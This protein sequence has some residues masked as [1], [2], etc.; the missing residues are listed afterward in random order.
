MPSGYVRLAGDY[1][2]LFP[3]RRERLERLMA[4]AGPAPARVLEL[5]C[6]PGAYLAALGRCGYQVAGLELD[7]AMHAAGLKRHPE[8]E[9]KLL[10][11]DLLEGLDCLRGPFALVFCAGHAFP[12]L[13]SLDEVAQG[14]SQM[15]DLAWPGGKALLALPNFNHLAQEAQRVMKLVRLKTGGGMAADEPPHYL[16]L[17]DSAPQA[18]SPQLGSVSAGEVRLYL[19]PLSATRGDGARIELERCYSAAPETW[20]DS[21]D[22]G[23]VELFHTLRT[24]EGESSWSFPLLALTALVLRDCLDRAA[25]ICARPHTDAWSGSWDGQPWSAGMAQT[26]VELVSG[27]A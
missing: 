9:G 13:A 12:G 7:P 2:L 20:G 27:P 23:A 22:G 18:G 14:L 24:P 11:G 17:L 15:L 8:L 26:I 1:H 25:G 6:G 3:P 5:G 16:E 19:P 21:I 10:H 4:C